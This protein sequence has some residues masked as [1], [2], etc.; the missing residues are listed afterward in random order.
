MKC[1]NCGYT[2]NKVVDSRPTGD[3]SIRRRRECLSCKFRFTTYEFIE[4]GPNFVVKKN[5][6]REIFDRNKILT[7]L[8]KACYKRPV[9]NDQLENIVNEIEATIGN[10]MKHEIK[11][12][13][14]GEMVMEKL[15]ELDDVSYVRFAS[16][17]RRFRDVDSFMKELSDLKDSKKTKQNN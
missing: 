2:D 13:D 5:G 3:S 12:S 1:P 11:S 7:G 14:I 4:V 10:S 8:I 16:V 6:T 9:T 17:Y 15:K